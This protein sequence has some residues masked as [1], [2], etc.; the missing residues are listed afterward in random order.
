MF[1]IRRM[2]VVGDGIVTESGE[3]VTS[4]NYRSLMG[5]RFFLFTQL[6]RDYGYKPGDSI[7]LTEY[8]CIGAEGAGTGNVQDAY[9][10]IDKRVSVVSLTE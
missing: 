10:Y 4:Q 7:E 2:Q 5:E 8:L 1:F 3:S 6:L 9:H